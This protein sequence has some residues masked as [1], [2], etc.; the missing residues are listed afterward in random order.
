MLD[1]QASVL[2]AAQKA[3]I[4]SRQIDHVLHVARTWSRRFQIEAER[5][6]ALAAL[7]DQVD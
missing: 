5:T 4:D 7:V 1:D 3:D 6:T 2:E